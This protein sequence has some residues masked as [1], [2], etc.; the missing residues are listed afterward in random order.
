MKAEI[1]TKE[2]AFKPIEV[3][4]T[5]ESLE[6]LR[7]LCKRLHLGV[8]SLN[9]ASPCYGDIATDT[10]HVLWQELDKLYQSLK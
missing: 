4:I 9:K 1:T 10:T 7:E 3:K 6:E 5:I 2:K 8:N